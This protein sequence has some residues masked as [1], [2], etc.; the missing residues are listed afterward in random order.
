MKGTDI[1]VLSP[2][3]FVESFAASTGRRVIA[4]TETGQRL[5]LG[6]DGARILDVFRTP[7]KISSAASQLGLGGHENRAKLRELLLPLL[8]ASFL[9]PATDTRIQSANAALFAKSE[10]A[11]AN[12]PA[13]DVSQLEPGS[14][15]I[16]GIPSDRAVTGHP[17]ARYGPDRLREVSRRYISYELDVVTLK[18]VGFYSADL[19]RTILKDVVV[20]D[21][22][23]VVTH[24]DEDQRHFYDRCYRAATSIYSKQALPVFIG[25]DHSISAP[26]VRAAAERHGDITI[27]HFDAH[28]DMAEFV[29][30]AE[31]HHGN[32]MSRVLQENAGV[33][34][35]QYGI[36]GFIKEPSLHPRWQ[37]VSQRFID[38]ELERVVVDH[39]PRGLKCYLSF[40]VDVLDPSAAPG[41]GTPLAFGME[42]K[43]FLCLLEAVARQNTIVGIDV[44][45]LCPP[46]DRNDMTT[47]LVFHAL[48]RLLGVIYGE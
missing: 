40:D 19:E 21:L 2:H 35:I 14:I 17:G 45:E 36:R 1:L 29:P 46:L 42:P 5:E 23:N 12:C 15:A 9:I 30:P 22:G 47:S 7:Q 20:A 28:T 8:Q 4:N 24:P 10:A 31:H 13:P 39:V 43:T 48:M 25:G 41:T 32:V 11:F 33:R 3:L 34:I 44:V 27:V 18:S 38:S 37:I 16:A 6:R 26:L